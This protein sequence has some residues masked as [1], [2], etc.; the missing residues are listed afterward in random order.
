MSKKPE[1]KKDQGP[2]T[3]A[4]VKDSKTNVAKAEPPK[5]EKVQPIKDLKAP[6]KSDVSKD[7]KIPEPKIPKG[8][9]LSCLCAI[10][11]Y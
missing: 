8:T 3:T 4:P 11:P 6:S 1:P 9:S 5:N 7:N 2:T 10:K